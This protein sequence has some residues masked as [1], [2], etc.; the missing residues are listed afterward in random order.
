MSNPF[1]SLNLEPTDKHSPHEVKIGLVDQSGRY[2]IGPPTRPPIKHDN[3]HL[4][5]YKPRAPTLADRA[6]LA[7]W[8]AILEGSEALCNA[9][10]GSIT[11]QC[12]Y[13]DLSDGNAAYRH[14]LFGNGA[15]RQFNYERFLQNDPAAKN[16][17]R[18]LVNDF[19]FHISIIGKDRVSF[20]VTSSTYSVQRGGIAPYPLTANW[21]KAI[22][23]H[24]FWVSAN[25]SASAV[26]DK[27]YY[28]ADITIHVE[29]RF[30]FNIGAA[31]AATGIPDSAN[32]IFEITG[33]GKQY[34]N[35]STV[36][37]H[38]RWEDGSATPT[39]VTGAP[40]DRQRMPADNRRLRN[41]I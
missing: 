20:M 22:G 12:N 36:T 9:Q 5:L 13:E 18:D 24:V 19:E 1:E 31:D 38:V 6:K 16:L 21:Q 33:L 40:V 26:G 4:E 7:G 3:G 25:V 14:F 32:G 28:D 2:K 35:F 17:I 11:P 41:K 30:N 34:M 39:Q 23:G 8:I 37:R 10:T 15:D 29:D 27:I